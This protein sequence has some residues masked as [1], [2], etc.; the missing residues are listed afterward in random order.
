MRSVHVVL[1]YLADQ[2][3]NWIITHGRKQNFGNAEQLIKAGQQIS[4]VYILL[5]GELSIRLG[6][7]EEKETTRRYPGE[8]I[9]ELS[10]LDSR[11]PAESV[12]AVNSATVIALDRKT[13]ADN[14]KADTAFAAR[15]FRALGVM[16]ASRFRQSMGQL[17]LRQEYEELEVTSADEIDPDLL[18]NLSL[19]G[20]RFELIRSHF[21]GQV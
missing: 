7:A 11:A 2:D 8:F 12:F 17:T 6:H 9:G 4:D 10:F 3:I 13:I 16:L 14:L 19:A 1:G 18:D 21:L 5:A 20:Q 15:F